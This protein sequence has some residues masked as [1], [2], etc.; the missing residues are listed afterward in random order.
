MPKETVELSQ[1][2][3]AQIHSENGM[4]GATS[5][6]ARRTPFQWKQLPQL[7][8]GISSRGKDGK[9]GKDGS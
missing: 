8:L 2:T 6:M 4:P 1:M 3:S 5:R 7:M 9:D